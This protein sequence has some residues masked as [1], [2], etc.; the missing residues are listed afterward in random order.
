MVDEE[1]G[2][3]MTAR[4]MNMLVTSSE[5]THILARTLDT[6]VITLLIAFM[7]TKKKLNSLSM[8]HLTIQEIR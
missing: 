7:V 5:I 8:S 1:A 6:D 3:I 2:N 4:I